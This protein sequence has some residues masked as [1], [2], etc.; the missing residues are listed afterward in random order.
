MFLNALNI[1]GS[2]LTA[3]QYRLNLIAQNIANVDTTRTESGGPYKRKVPV[4][5]ESTDYN[6]YNANSTF[7]DYLSYFTYLGKNN[8]S[9]DANVAYNGKA[10]FV[11]PN[12]G[13]YALNGVSPQTSGN[14][15]KNK[16]NL[17]DNN[18]NGN[19]GV[20]IT[21]VIDDPTPGKMVY[22]PENPDANAD[23]Y[24]EMPN[25]D[26][27]QEMVDMMGASRSYEANVQA[28]NAIKAMASKALEI[29]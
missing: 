24:V 16:Y 22:D 19:G 6:G 11:K 7:T 28:V 29:K 17:S 14:F 5:Q 12:L 10:V 25:V 9:T 23:G 8:N 26:M 1:S 20:K 2:A 3:E 21:K 18:I 27:T 13:G 4:F 15:V